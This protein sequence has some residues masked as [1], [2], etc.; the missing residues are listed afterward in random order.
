MKKRIILA[1]I[2]ML[3]AVVLLVTYAIISE[4]KIPTVFD[5]IKNDKIWLFNVSFIILIIIIAII[6]LILIYKQYK[7]DKEVEEIED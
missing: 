1:N 3:F 4:I 7:E 6:V 2:L 5:N